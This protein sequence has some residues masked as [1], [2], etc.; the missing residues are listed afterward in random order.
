MRVTVQCWSL[1]I[2]QPRSLHWQLLKFLSELK[3]KAFPPVFIM[4]LTARS[5]L[6]DND[7]NTFKSQEHWAFNGIWWPHYF[8][9]VSLRHLDED[10]KGGPEVN[11]AGRM[12]PL[13]CI[14]FWSCRTRPVISGGASPVSQIAPA[15]A[16]SL[17]PDNWTE[18]WMSVTVI[19]ADPPRSLM[20][21]DPS[22]VPPCILTPMEPH[23]CV[24]HLLHLSE[25]HYYLSSI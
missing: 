20:T 12:N 5:R 10:F 24:I 6:G 13:P 11:P 23:W 18:G 16:D 14:C 9:L 3:H 21:S 22:A 17:L 25:W 8:S 7:D 4:F 15:V 2:V 19:P 1:Q